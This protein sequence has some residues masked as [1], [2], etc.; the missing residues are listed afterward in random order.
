MFKRSPCLTYLY[1]A[2]D[3]T[4]PP[5]KVLF[6]GSPSADMNMLTSKERKEREPRATQATRV[7]DLVATKDTIMQEVRLKISHPL[8]S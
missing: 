8:D 2:L 7:K 1:G 4:P 3:T 5:P 6:R